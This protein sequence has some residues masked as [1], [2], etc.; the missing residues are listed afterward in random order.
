MIATLEHVV[1]IYLGWLQPRKSSALAISG[2]QYLKIAMRLLRNSDHVKIFI[3]KSAPILLLYTLALQLALLSKWGIDFM[4]CNPTSARGRGYIILAV[5]YFTKWVEEIP[6]YAED[7]NIVA[8]F[9]FN[10]VIAIFGVS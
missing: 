6:T 1:V 9:L 8:L 5:D 2:L 4:H 10:H 7:G 3:Q